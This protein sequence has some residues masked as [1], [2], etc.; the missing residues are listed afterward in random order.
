MLSSS[1]DVYLAGKFCWLLPWPSGGPIR[2]SAEALAVC[3]SVSEEEFVIEQEKAGLGRKGT[4]TYQLAVGP[5]ILDEP[6]DEVY[7]A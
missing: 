2:M 6:E 7:E 3:G 4:C 5:S 1:G